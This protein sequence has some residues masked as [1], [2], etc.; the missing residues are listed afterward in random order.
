V[1]ELSNHERRI[2]D[3]AIRSFRDIA[4]RDYITARLAARAGLIPQ[5]L[6]SSLQAFEKYFKCIL[7]L[8]RISSKGLNH[9]IEDALKLVRKNVTYVDDMKPDQH[10]VFRQVALD[11]GDRYLIGSYEA[12][13]PL[14]P[15]L[16]AAI[17]D[18]RRYCQA[19]LP[20]SGDSATEQRIF[21]LT[22]EGLVN[23]RSEPHRFKIAGGL[24]ESVVSVRNHPAH[25]ALCWQNAF[26]GKSKRPTV[27]AQMYME[28]SNAPLWLYPEM[29]D[30]LEKLIQI[31]SNM[32]DGYRQHRDDIAKGKKPR[33]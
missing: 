5:F 3:F 28:F 30:D 4:D 20:H 8:N 32:V 18:V 13:G 24:L 1:S 33:P 23:A 27:R 26:Y 22:V 19:L 25:I 31:G 16:D 2:N 9:R 6:W 11:G 10:D 15:Q 29:I 12:H 17:W 14:L 7:L 21:E